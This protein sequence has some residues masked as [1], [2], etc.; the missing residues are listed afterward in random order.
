MAPLAIDYW[1][2]ARGLEIVAEPENTG[3]SAG[4]GRYHFTILSQAEMEA[5]RGQWV[6]L[7]AEITWGR[8]D[9]ATKGSLRVWLAGEKKPRVAVSGINTHWPQQQ[10]VTFWEGMYHRQGEP[11]DEF[12]RHRRHPLRQ[13]SARSVQGCTSALYDLHQ[14]RAEQLE[15][16][17]PASPLRRGPSARPSE[18]GPPGQMTMLF[19]GQGLL[20]TCGE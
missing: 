18:V 3:C 8:R 12:G 4:R 20:T 15:R 7:W 11:G 10:M 16:F 2:N 1:G 13:H 17:H 5:R 19:P 6:W 9:L 14:Q